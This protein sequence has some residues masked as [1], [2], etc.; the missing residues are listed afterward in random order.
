MANANEER[1]LDYLKRVTYELHQTQ[2]H[3]REVERRGLEPIAIVAMSCR[4]PGG[5]RTPE[6]LWQLLQR[7]TD[8]ISAFP[9]GRGWNLDELYHPDPDVKGKSYVREGGFLHD[10]AG[11]DPTF[12]G[13]SPS[14]AIAID[15]Q[16]RLLLETSWEAIER[17]GID[18]ATLHGSQTGV[19]L[20]VIYN[21]YAARLLHAPDTLEGHIWI[22]STASVASG[23]IA[24][25]LGLE[26]PA[27]TI[28]TACSSSLV[29]LHLA[30][31][32]LRHGECSLALTGGVSVMATPTAFIEFSRQRGLAPDGRCKAFSADAS[33]TGWAEGI[34]MLLLERLSDARRHGHPILALVRGSA[35][36]QDG[37][38]QG[39]TAPNGPSQQRVIQ[40]AL[41]SAQ[42]SAGE[43]DAVEAH[44]TGTTL[45]DPIEAQALL[46]T[47][48]QGHSEAQ[49]LWLGAIK[50]NLGHTQAAA[51]VAGII[52]MVLAMQHG[53]LPRTLHADSPSP[54]VDWSPGTV[55]LLTEPMPWPTHGHPHRA[56]VSAFGISGTNAHVILEQAPA[57]ELTGRA[58]PLAALPSALPLLVS[59][60]T[61][62]ALRAQAERLR[63]HLESHPDLRLVDVA[64][65]LATTRSHFERR[66]VVVV[67]DRAALIDAL[68]A[69]AQ[70]NPTPDVVLGEAKAS[71][72]LALLFTGQ[73][74]QRPGMG[75]ALH[76]A[77]PAFRD[78]LDAACGY[79]DVQFDRPLRD[80]LFATDGS[81]DAALLDQTAFTQTALFALE[82]ALFRL[83]ET[84]G[85]KPDLLLGHSIGELVAAHVAGVLSLEDACVLVTAR[86]RLMQALPQG[87]AMVS[88]QASEDEV[89]PLLVGREDRVALAALNGL[90][91]TVVSG[92]EDAVLEVAQRIEALGRKTT[93]L[94]VSHAFHSPRM[95]GMLEAFRRVAGGLTF[96]PPRIPIISNITGKRATAEELGSPG[97]WVR[98]ARQAVRFVDGVRTLEA[99]GVTSFL[100]LGPQGVLCA[101]AQG[102]LSEEAQAGSAFLPVLRNDRPEVQ[103]LI[104]ALGGLAT[105]GHELDWKVF[106]APFG[107]RVVPLPTY[108]FQR[109]RYWLE[110]PK[111]PT[112]DV[113]SAGLASADH[114]LLNAAVAL[115]DADE[116]LF[117]GRLSLES[118][119]WLVG[120]VVF[121]TVL[122]P[123]TA[124]L[125]LALVAAHRVGQGRVDELTV[126]APLALPPKGAVHLQLYVGTLDE[127]GRRSLT[128]HSRLEDAP[129]DTP[130]S[131]H[132]TGT[133][134][135]PAE[136]ATFDLRAWP[137][138][139]AVATD[140]DGLYDHLADA[141]LACGHDFQGLYAAWKRG[142]DLF[143]EVR[144]PEGSEEDASHFGLHPALLDAALHALAIETLHDTGGLALP[145]SWAGVSLH[146]TGASTLRVRL[147]PLD[148]SGGAS[149][150]IADASGEP[151][152][153]VDA[154]RTRPVFPEPLQG[155]LASHRDLLYRVDWMTLPEASAPPPA[156]HWALLG[157]D[158]VGLSANVQAAAVRVDGHAD[159]AVLQAALAR[160]ERVP[161]IVVIPWMAQ[162][163]DSAQAAHDAT[164]RG[165]SL[166]QAWLADER[167]VSCRLVVLTRR[168][169]ATRPDEDVLDLVHAPLWGL[170]RTAQSEHPDRLLVLVDLDEHEASLRA[171]PS[172]LAFNEPQLAV[173]DG[174]L[175]VPRLAR[176]AASSD[177]TIRLWD[178]E[179]TMLITG[180]TGPL[181]ALIVRHLVAKHGVRH[182]LLTSRQGRSAFGAETLESELTA[183]GA[184]VTLAAC[185]VA[186]RDALM[187]LLASIP[188]DHPLKGVIHAA[189]V[190][191]DGALLSLNPERVDRVLRPKVDAAL[192]LHELTKD[193]DVSAFVLFSSFAGVL[194][195][196]GQSNYAAANT[197]LDALAHRRR[198]QGRPGTSLAWGPWAKSRDMTAHLGNADLTRL[199]R[200]GVAALSPE[201]GLALFDAA[202]FRSD[203]FLVPACLDTAVL[204]AQAGTLPPLLRGL[205]RGTAR[206]PVAAGAWS[207]LKKRL[208]ALSDTDRT[209]ALLDLVRSEVAVVLGLTVPNAIEPNRPLREIGLDSL[210]ALKLGNRLGHATGLRLPATLLFDQ[211]T[212]SALVQRLRAEMLDLETENLASSPV[213]P[214]ASDSEPIA[215]VA[216]SCRY[217]G[218]VRTPE[219]LW[220]LLQGGTDAISSFPS[221]RGWN[222]D[223][224]YDPD[225]DAKGK[226]YVREGGFL[227]DAD[228]FDPLFFGISPREALA[229]DPQQR[230]LLEV[231]WEAMERAGID[232]AS[233]HGSQ[234]G[235]FVGISFQDYG[236]RVLQAPDDLEGYI[237]IGSTASIASGRIAYTLELEG[238]AISVDTAC[239]SSLVTL[240]LA[241][242]ALRHGECSLALA[243]G[244][245]VMATPAAFIE[246]SRLRALAPD[247]R[248]KAFSADANG[249][250]FA[251]GVGMLLLERLSDARRHGHP[252]LALVRG[253]A[254]NQDGKSQG[255][256]APNGPSQQRVIRQALDSA[257]L[258]PGEVDA[259]ETHGTGTTLGDPIEI[260]ALLATYGQG[261]S[262]DQPLWLGSIKSNLGHTQA[263]AG[264]AGV[265]K[266]V[267]AMQHELLPRTLHA[268]SPSP[269]VDW[270]PGT[271]RLLTE[272]TPW[273]T[274]GHP[275]R[276]GIS[277]FGI[278]GTNAHILLEEAPP[279]EPTTQVEPLAALPPVLPI[280]VSARTEAALRTQAARLRV[281]LESHPDLGL[282]DVAYSLATTRSHFERRAAVVAHDR[283]ALIDALDALARGNSAP[284]VVLGEAKGGGK[285]AL[286]FTGQGSQRPGM[287][288]AL[289]DAFPIFRDAFD[290]VCARLDVQLDRPLREVLFAAEGSED[291]ALLDQTAFTQT[292]LFAL[293]VALFR[294]VEVW[295]LKPDLLLSHSIGELV[296]AHVA[297]VLSLEDAC[298]LVAARARLMQA[299]P[300]GGAMVSL[301][302]SED[303]IRALLAGREDHLDIAAV[304]GPL[305]TVVSGDLDAVVEVAKHFETLGPQST[306]LQ[307]SHAFHS[308]HMEGML[309]AFRRVASGLTF[310]RPRIPIVSNVT[311]ELATAEE[312]GSPD[313]WVRHVRQA[314]RFLDGVRTLEAE[315]VTTF[316]EL[317]PHG[318]LCAMAQGC[319]SEEAQARAAFLPALRKE[320]PEVEAL[321]AA[322]GGLHARGHELDWKAFFAPFGARPAA[323]PT[324]AFQRERYWLEASKAGSADVASAG[325][326]SADHPLLGAAVALAD[327]DGFLFT[328]RLSLESHPWLA[329]YV[330]FDTVLLPGTALVELALVAAHRVAQGRVDELT[331]EAP[332]AL[333]PK[334]GVHLQLSVGTP[335][336]AGR[337]SLAL[338][339]RL[340]DAPPDAPWSRHATGTLGPI[341]ES[342]PF[343]LRAWPPAEAVLL[344][345][346]GLYDRLTD[347]GLAYG[348]DFQGL[349]AAWK[350]GD[351]LFAEVRLP[352]GPAQDAGHFGLHPALLD[353]A[354]HALTIE[355]LHGGGDV[356]LPFSW[357]G[358]SLY[359]TGAS[360]LRVH[361]SCRDGEGAVSLAIADASG[362]PIASVE[363]LRTRP[364]SPEQLQSALASRHDLLYRVDW[365]TLPEAAAP[366]PAGHWALLGIDKAEL[367][368][369]LEAAAVR[370]DGHADLTAL[371]AALAQGEPLPEVVMIPWMAGA[372]DSASAAHEAT[373]RGLT[374]LQA[375]C[376]D[377][378]LASCRLVLLTHRAIAT[379]P[380]EGVLDLARAPLWGLVRSAQSEHPDRALVLI[381]LDDHE[382]SRRAL[383]AALASGEPQLAVRDGTLRVPRLARI[384]ASSEATVRPLDPEGTVLI[385]GGTG[386]LGALFARHLVAKHGVRHLLLTSR[387]GR[388]APGAET[389]K[390]E[391]TAAGARVMLAACDVAD[392]DALQQLLASVPSDHPLTGVIHAAGVLDDGVLLSLTPERV[393][394]VLRPKVD[395]ALHLHELTQELNLSAFVLFS[396]LAGVLGSLGQ[397][398]YAAAN[399]FLDALAHQRRAQGRPATS[400]AWGYWADRG[401]MTAHLGGADLRRMTRLGMSP[402]S[403]EDGLAL[404]NAALLRPDASLVLARFRP[405]AWSAQADALPLLLRGLVRTAAR[406]AVTAGAGALSTLKQR[407]AALSE[408]DRD[409]ALLDLVRTEVTTVL[410]L[411][412]P[413]TV[414]PN[415]PLQEL[416]LDSLMALELRNRLGNVT[417]LRLPA[418]LLFDHPTPAAL[419]RLLRAETLPDEATTA[420]L[421][422]TEFDKLEAILSAMASNDTVRASLTMRLQALLSKWTDVQSA[423]AGP[424]VTKKLQSATD[425]ELFDFIDQEFGA[426]GDVH[427]E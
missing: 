30:C 248:C 138:A 133:L 290:A 266:M 102:C 108:A 388:D 2:E 284:T 95:E 44:G 381:D 303:E 280:L 72:K 252:V 195:G 407:L 43:I 245:C 413:S 426:Q 16:Q 37:K 144:L 40:Q 344:D 26:G 403:L 48:G 364:A 273:P 271:V 166:L 181:G 311:G 415:R 84:W 216:M 182:L 342:A 21:D 123:G 285:L 79:L 307:V 315:G 372:G 61:E 215:I 253:S 75:R 214:A 199:A 42:L 194:G 49:P 59:G 259:V 373:H 343:D 46:A 193:L 235:V 346:D 205:V 149:L 140:L 368:A 107:A 331:L 201:D 71:G 219:E 4:F 192:H 293:E 348:H 397:S 294:L 18:P 200:I 313:Y 110:A 244:V 131:R 309:E 270:S 111:A 113:A 380:D 28:D 94:R 295:G 50:S 396:S 177:E 80:V 126:Q 98:H 283:S 254:V 186:D 184:H 210:M 386:K 238:P 302:A 354:L 150:A 213:L 228:H 310:H 175:L 73:G 404:F 260:Q 391:L 394:R 282:V 333:P 222:V 171:L 5:I 289:Y 323:L 243:G 281:H 329:G 421:A 255:L 277:S 308:P 148:G 405:A 187:Q 143:A 401:G 12:F 247:G 425:D 22:G 165:L 14:E 120:Y 414:K 377:E 168:A 169:I 232:P 246:F 257:Q 91:S 221:E 321:T 173:R 101:M 106:F 412:T 78:A 220:Q 365:T 279:V 296:A 227:H 135:P 163:G 275:R 53:L 418:T 103:T 360:A 370:V 288:R 64:Y 203:A 189:A 118:H 128:L 129:P 326:A 395:A 158:D 409:R 242:Q 88:L 385:T 125:E 367:I 299:L 58:E 174:S 286:L 47:Y 347:A 27:V 337:R 39:L 9:E 334:G 234:T 258:S 237:G 87:G 159:L 176:M 236:A 422:V 183:A 145:F 3:L 361:L 226:S 276:A 191:D 45:G 114:P 60:K 206:R 38:S 417:G 141:G 312:L 231:S 389:L 56:G 340:E 287:G 209:R 398:N 89:K 112:A 156:W 350:R 328:G 339:S 332:L 146:V 20:G 6:E 301:Q 408:A 314:V 419:A 427:G 170:V 352:E 154:L 406:R 212:P 130:W 379:R 34:G 229:I 115:A 376:A 197:F 358:V 400:L 11:F 341:T 327:A 375:W 383:P 316:L 62:A 269:H 272:H 230:L 416:G 97:Y 104:A 54:H 263:A 190:L 70:D 355:A 371:K 52:K 10:A 99:E 93:R 317:G 178:P 25:T 304:N 196:S 208:A 119:P 268:D 306:R 63:T 393:D 92:D 330:V 35:V 157:A 240:H 241:C 366:P 161:E 291:A 410:G 362:E 66:A 172:A 90:L 29:S 8:A 399:S 298:T 292:A 100:E 7:G 336:E 67:S 378:R 225:P 345:L 390:S 278:S 116:F 267:L 85:L 167:L 121:D 420:G 218:G 185:D 81:E 250:G 109:E 204:S 320:R 57:A 36:N 251:E 359:A 411:T 233:L 17:A 96:H 198:A 325:L 152:A 384:A 151:I 55:R 369:E 155:A 224:L 19:F 239:S 83:V 134:G 41:E 136:S 349:C 274:L 353:A 147:S 124:F 86:A 424:S 264:V 256:T 262:R 261:H 139:G 105:R 74:S 137:P 180:G 122:L 300:Q 24:Y 23:R 77:F 160:G 338:H 363:A 324:Y 65:S 33:G 202:L 387:Q 153:S 179:G 31:Q 305:S 402:L 265:I 1:L 51:G 68:G 13:I 69:L 142:D 356:A 164:H 15:P 351:D 357:A 382:T 423:T 207:S 319:L 117:T 392:R 82:V 76:E 374:L 335:D 223:E 162:A 249:T 211:P 318:V 132:A 188:S 217:P 297:G 127:A 322:L 32:A